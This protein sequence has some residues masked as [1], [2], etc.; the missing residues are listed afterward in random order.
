MQPLRWSKIRLQRFS[1]KPS[2]NLALPFPLSPISLL[3][4]PSVFPRHP[5]L[6]PTMSPWI[7]MLLE[8]PEAHSPLM[9]VNA[10]LPT[11]CV[12]IVVSRVTSLLPASLP[13]AFALVCTPDLFSPFPRTLI[14]RR[15]VFSP[16]LLPNNICQPHKDLFRVPR[17]P[18]PL[19][20]PPLTHLPTSQK[21]IS[22]PTSRGLA[23]W[24]SPNPHTPSL[25]S[26]LPSVS[27]SPPPP[28]P[29]PPYTCSGVSRFWRLG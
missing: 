29:P 2:S 7:W 19:P 25:S 4:L 12:V 1:P 26:T 18:F 21:T 6:S 3:P 5:L 8:V 14:T 20:T 13:P 17:W 15:Q 22:Q 23:G 10:G 16:Y 28:S 27:S 11:A 24:L 9:N